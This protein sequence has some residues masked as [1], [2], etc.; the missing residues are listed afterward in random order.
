VF[1]HHFGI[2]LA[3]HRRIFAAFFLYSFGVGGF[4]PR[5][6]EIQR[7]MGVAEG[8]L[9]L[10]LIGTAAGT[11]VSL[12]LAGP[13][14][15]RFG[16]RRALLVLVPLIPACY[17]LAAIAP[18][19]LILFLCLFPAGLCMGA[20]EIVVNLEADRF[21]HQSGRRIMNRSHAFWSFG[22][23][24]AAILGAGLSQLRVSPALHLT[25]MVAVVLLAT[26][27][28][29]V[30]FEPAP[31]RVNAGKDKATPRFARPTLAIV[32]LVTVTLSA[33]VLEGAGIDWSAIYMR[34]VFHS[35]PFIT[36]LAVAV[37]VFAQA[38]TRYVTDSY[39]EEHSPVAVARALLIILGIGDLL[40]FLAPSAWLALLGF[41]AIGV[42]TSAIYPLAMSAA[43]QRAD[44]AAAVNVASLAQIA[45]VTF[46]L[47][48]PLLGHVAERWGIRWSFGVALPL[49]LLSLAVSNVL[50]PQRQR[51]AVV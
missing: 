35:V 2:D 49:V 8:A 26:T 28:F 51:V 29:L 10:A 47:A 36:G 14:I 9:G 4:F 12:S 15:E 46:L 43:A 1:P 40:V 17:A 48:P 24:S 30:R 27:V 7:T 25:L 5:L 23:F 38:L 39:V 44:R 45:V 6:A 41:A 11:L 42:G 19:P 32:M 13:L 50:R 3:P 20:I 37:N 33:M 31:G 21:E 18:G 34:D 22:F 16:H